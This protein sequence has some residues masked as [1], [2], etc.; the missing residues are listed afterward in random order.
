VRLGDNETP[1]GDEDTNGGG[2]ENADNWHGCDPDNYEDDCF[3]NPH[4]YTT[5]DAD[6][7]E[8]FQFAE[9]S[10]YIEHYTTVGD[11]RT[12]SHS[13]GITQDGVMSSYAWY[14]TL[15]E[16]RSTLKAVGQEFIT[17]S[18]NEWEESTTETTRGWR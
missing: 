13:I 1:D 17:G 5:S 14:L 10:N 6:F 12:I 3:D 4:T 8:K 9:G 16:D 15:S 18:V 11:S 7:V 2:E